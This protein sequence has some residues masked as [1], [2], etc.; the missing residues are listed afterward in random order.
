MLS[1]VRQRDHFDSPL[2][3]LFPPP[4]LPAP[5]LY[6]RN[7][8]VREAGTGKK[9]VKRRNPKETM[10]TISTMMTKRKKSTTAALPVV[11]LASM[12]RW[13]DVRRFRSLHQGAVVTATQAQ[14]R[15]LDDVSVVDK[16]TWTPSMTSIECTQEA[17]TFFR[18]IH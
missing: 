4:Y 17:F 12:I 7:A 16:M 14:S 6:S 15:Q 8:S 11:T 1:G 18:V 2:T 13:H 9:R 3:P 10:T 5:L